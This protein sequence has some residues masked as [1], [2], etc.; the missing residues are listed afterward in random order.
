MHM[1]CV[2]ILVL[3]PSL[4]PLVLILVLVMVFVTGLGTGA[5][6]RSTAM[7]LVLQHYCEV[8]VL[9]KPT[10]P[11]GGAHRPYQTLQRNQ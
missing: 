6:R 5:T 4:A 11:P 3:T 8:R 10:E 1:I 9:F 7:A 2:A